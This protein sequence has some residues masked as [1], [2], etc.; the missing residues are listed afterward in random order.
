MPPSTAGWSRHAEGL[1]DGRITPLTLTS[2]MSCIQMTTKR[3]RK[4]S[5]LEWP[6]MPPAR[7]S[8]W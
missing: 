7:S 8:S 6:R 5:L 4:G 3:L 2:Y 1:S